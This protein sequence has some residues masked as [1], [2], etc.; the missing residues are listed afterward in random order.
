M[1]VS[2]VVG[3][4]AL[5]GILGLFALVGAVLAVVEKHLAPTR[6]H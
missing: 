2:A 4:T 6:E 1:S 3:T 5:L